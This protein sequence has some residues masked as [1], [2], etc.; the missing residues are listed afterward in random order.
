M[1]QAPTHSFLLYVHGA[2]ANCSISPSTQLHLTC[3]ESWRGG[4][5]ADTR[6]IAILRL[7]AA[8]DVEED[9]AGLSV[10]ARIVAVQRT[11]P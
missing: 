7:A 5:L 4:Q 6:T 3:R 2:K 11:G 9:C 1:H 10:L 8:G